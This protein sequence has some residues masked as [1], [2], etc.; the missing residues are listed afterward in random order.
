[1]EEYTHAHKLEFLRTISLC[2]VAQKNLAVR[3]A[4]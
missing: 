3:N 1:V 2:A 4:T